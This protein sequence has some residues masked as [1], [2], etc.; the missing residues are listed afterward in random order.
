MPY[1][2]Q[3]S[4]DEII[5]S[6]GTPSE[7]SIDEN[8]KYWGIKTTKQN[9]VEEPNTNQ[10]QNTS[11]ISYLK[12]FPTFMTN[13]INPWVGD[14]NGIDDSDDTIYDS[15]RFNNA[16]F[17]LEN[18]LI[19]TTS[20]SEDIVDSEQWAYARYRPD[21]TKIP[22]ID[23]TLK[24]KSGV[25]FFDFSKD[26]KGVGPNTYAGFTVPLQGGFDGFDMFSI[27][28][29]NFSNLASYF[30]MQDENQG[31]KAGATTA[32]YLTALRILEEKSEAAIKLLAIPGIRLEAI[33][34]KALQVAEDRFDAFYVM[35]IEA[36]L[37]QG[38]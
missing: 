1:R 5:P 27:E 37:D 34:N 7:K 23:K 14:N 12:Y 30:E 31:R 20:I 22:L 11:F 9:S 8:A 28:K 13:R 25:R 2:I 10:N 16:K 26:L 38:H 21:R 29:T 17:S 19:H 3:L 32:A 35:D 36:D 4:S 33:T 6:P 24:L 18:I 15:D